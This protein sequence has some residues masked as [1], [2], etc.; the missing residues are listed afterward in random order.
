M[1]WIQMIQNQLSDPDVSSALKTNFLLDPDNV[2][3]RLQGR[4]RT[5]PLELAKLGALSGKLDYD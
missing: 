5:P 4:W 3:T 2:M 1:I